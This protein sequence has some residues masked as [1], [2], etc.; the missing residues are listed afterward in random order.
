MVSFELAGL[1]DNPLV[2]GPEWVVPA[3]ITAQ[4]D[5]LLWAAWQG[6]TGPRAARVGVGC[7]P[8][9]LRLEHATADAIVE[10]AQRWGVLQ[11]CAHGFPASHNPPAYPLGGGRVTHCMPLG[12]T[13]AVCW[14]PLE[15]WRVYAT[16]MR[17]LRDLAAQLHQD[18]KGRAEDW[19]IVWRDRRIPPGLDAQRRGLVD[20]LNLLVRMAH[21]GLIA[22]WR[23]QRP[24]FAWGGSGLFGALVM[25]LC[26]MITKASPAMC[27]GCGMFYQAV[28]R[29]PRYDRAAYC[30]GCRRK[31]VPQ[32]DAEIAHRKR[33]RDA[34]ELLRTGHPL[35]EVA[36]QFN[37]SPQDIRR[38]VKPPVKS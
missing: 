37:K 7:L 38:W 3:S 16:Y 12:W 28:G 18:K 35:R 27:S 32:R 6:E 24:G 34:R 2:S 21:V 11:I 8:R 1:T 31:G 36:R 4:G 14:E 15:A 13:E 30:P 26:A 5:R 10:F 25:Q 22:S 9:F 20:R 29:R 17:A 33:K 23:T 19:Q